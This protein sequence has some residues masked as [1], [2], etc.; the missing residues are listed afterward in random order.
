MVLSGLEGTYAVPLTGPVIYSSWETRPECQPS[1]SLSRK[2]AVIPE[3]A[4]PATD[5]YLAWEAAATVARVTV[6]SSL[7]RFAKR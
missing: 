1:S 3:R 7:A 6:R 5:G 2:G 4:W